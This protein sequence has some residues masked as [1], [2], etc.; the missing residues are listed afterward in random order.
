MERIESPGATP[1]ARRAG[2]DDHP[3]PGSPVWVLRNARF[4]RVVATAQE[5]LL[6]RVRLDGDGAHV[7]C[8]GEDLFALHDEPGTDDEARP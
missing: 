4:G 1:A 8:S 6:Y 3:G 2:A 5:G 7:V